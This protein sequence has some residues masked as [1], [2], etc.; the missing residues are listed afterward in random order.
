MM[1]LTDVNFFFFKEGSNNIKLPSLFLVHTQ[2]INKLTHEKEGTIKKIN[3]KKK[4]DLFWRVWFFSL[5]RYAVQ[6]SGERED[7]RDT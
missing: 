2:T 3:G 1:K 6:F 7:H 5:N 4:F